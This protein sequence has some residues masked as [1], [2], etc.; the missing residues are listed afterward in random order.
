MQASVHLPFFF[1]SCGAEVKRRQGFHAQEE[2]EEVDIVSAHARIM[3]NAD[4]EREKLDVPCFWPLLHI[5]ECI[6]SY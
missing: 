1:W 5:L 6:Y 4:A 2:G 3:M